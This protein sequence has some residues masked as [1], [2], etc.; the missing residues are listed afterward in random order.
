[1]TSS[2]PEQPGG[3]RLAILL[4]TLVCL[5]LIGRVVTSGQAALTDGHA[6]LAEGNEL[7]A[8]VAYREAISW[9]LPVV[10]PWRDEAADALWDMHL[11]QLEA[12]RLPAA[13]QSLQSLR[14]GLRSADSLW[15]P[16][17]ER[18]RLV[19]DT[20][21]PLMARWEADDAKASGRKS[22]GELASRTEHHAALLAQDE[23][24][25]R[26][27]GL[28]AVLGFGLWIGAAVRG[29][30]Q[31]GKGRVKLLALSVLGLTAFLTGLA[32]A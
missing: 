20:L 26:P 16:D 31:E 7:G 9:Y 12:D 32:L 29:L 2:E 25:S 5:T 23:R 15:R 4:V 21:A 18:K 10:A 30:K 13:V 28:L 3:R 17:Q 24:P 8:T 6:A 27:F 1:M 19:D 14:A 22:P 11:A